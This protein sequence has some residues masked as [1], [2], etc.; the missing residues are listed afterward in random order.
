VDTHESTLAS[1]GL[2]NAVQDAHQSRISRALYKVGNAVVILDGCDEGAVIRRKP[3]AEVDT[4]DA[5][6]GRVAATYQS[7]V[8]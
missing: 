5:K 7:E 8:R 6:E 2:D 1:V 4:F 3:S